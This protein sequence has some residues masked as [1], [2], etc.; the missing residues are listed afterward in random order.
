[1]EE[2]RLRPRAPPSN[3]HYTA[4]NRHRRDVIAPPSGFGFKGGA[5]LTRLRHR[6]LR[7][8]SC[9][10]TCSADISPSPA[11][12]IDPLTARIAK[13]L[14]PDADIRAQA[15]EQ[16]KTRDDLLRNVAIS[17]VPVWRLPPVHDP[18][19]TVT[20]FP[21]MIIFRGGAGKVRPGGFADVSF[22]SRGTMDKLDSHAA[23]NALLA[24]GVAGRQSAVP[25][26]ASS[27]R[28]PARKS[29][30]TS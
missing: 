20:N 18:R 11:L 21:S 16:T 24:H 23:R 5:S 19:W 26:D 28:T 27:K 25:N 9:P 17:N 1:M 6:P 8:A 3:A 15:F 22:T 7:W 10:K 14:Y 12:N 29:R 13:A 2:H 4:P 30:P